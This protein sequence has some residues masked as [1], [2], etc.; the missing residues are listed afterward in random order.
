MLIRNDEI[1]Q[2]TRK[3]F[4]SFVPNESGESGLIKRGAISTATIIIPD[5]AAPIASLEVVGGN[6]RLDG[7][8]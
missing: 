5:N 4:V 7:K 8:G 6:L 2:E 3:L 1:L